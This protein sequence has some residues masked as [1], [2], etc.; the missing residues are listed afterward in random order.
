MNGL[1]DDDNIQLTNLT[2][3]EILIMTCQKVN[4]LSR[5]VRQMEIAQVQHE[6]FIG[7][8]KEKANWSAVLWGS[9]ASAVISGL[10][11]LITSF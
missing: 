1:L 10:F 5:Q 7:Q 8:M 2:D 4:I 9:I 11:A 6:I 3:R